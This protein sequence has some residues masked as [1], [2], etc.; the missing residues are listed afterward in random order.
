M[1]RDAN[2]HKTPHFINSALPNQSAFAHN[3]SHQSST[4]LHVW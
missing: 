1:E 4:F 2:N 3:S